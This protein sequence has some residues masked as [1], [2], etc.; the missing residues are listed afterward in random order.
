MAR[1][2]QPVLTR[3]RIVDVATSI[4]DSEGFDA[5][6]TRRL[7]RELGVRAPSLYNHF[8]TKE[9][10]LDAVGD[11]I[12]ARVDVAMSGRDWSVALTEWARAYRRALAAHP[13]AVPFLARG[14][15][16]RPAGL[17]LADA[18]YGALADAGWP[19]SYA[20]R[21]GAALRYF[22][23]GSALGSFAQGFVDDPSSQIPKAGQSVVQIRDLKSLVIEL[24]P[25]LEPRVEDRG[26][27]KRGQDFD[28][29]TGADDEPAGDPL[30]VVDE[31]VPFGFISE[32]PERCDIGRHIA[33]RHA[34]VMKDHGHSSW[35]HH[36]SGFLSLMLSDSLNQGLE[37]RQP[38]QLRFVEG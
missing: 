31:L 37:I 9:E 22:V 1:P 11:G 6:S 30:A 33:T 13:N 5:L 3:Q 19:P 32:Q 12:I 25:F 34:H 16:R 4:V 24:D 38:R 7:A 20:T 23:M 10:I 18:V 27:G 36:S 35:P 28:A 15:A 29:G 2:R 17:A 26:A 8:A 21:I 14:P